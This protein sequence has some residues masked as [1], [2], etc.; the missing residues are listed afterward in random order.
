MTAGSAVVVRIS[1]Y[2]HGDPRRTGEA[3]E[4]D[5]LKHQVLNQ[6]VDQDEIRL[7]DVQTP[8]VQE[9]D[10]GETTEES[11]DERSGETTDE[12]SGETTD[13]TSE[14]RSGEKR[15]EKKSGLVRE[16]NALNCDLHSV[17]VPSE[18]TAESLMEHQVAD[19]VEIHRKRKDRA[20]HERLVHQQDHRLGSFHWNGKKMLARRARALKPRVLMSS[21][22]GVASSVELPILAIWKSAPSAV[23]PNQSWTFDLFKS[24]MCHRRWQRRRCNGFRRKLEGHLQSLPL[25]APN[26]LLLAKCKRP[27]WK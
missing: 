13:E 3:Q 9:K 18:R 22:S 25:W 6:E 24:G 11:T 20:R 5:G 17:R 7:A 10:E 1:Y 15:T 23:P 2:V 26:W 4:A 27:S 14:K 12:R 19:E 16:S 8:D 21:Q